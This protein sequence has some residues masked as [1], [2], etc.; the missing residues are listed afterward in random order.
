MT[1]PAWDP[2]PPAPPPVRERLGVAPHLRVP[3]PG[4]AA[5]DKRLKVRVPK[6]GG[7]REPCCH[8]WGCPR[9]APRDGGC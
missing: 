7:G 2:P 9:V 6:R 3:P 4:A 1:P 5:A 8:L